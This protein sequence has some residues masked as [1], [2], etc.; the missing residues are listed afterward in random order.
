MLLAL[1]FLANNLLPPLHLFQ[2]TF[3]I[4]KHGTHGPQIL[5]QLSC[6]PHSHSTLLQ[7]TSLGTVA[8]YLWFLCLKL[9]EDTH[10]PSLLLKSLS[11]LRCS[12]NDTS[13]MNFTPTLPV[14]IN[15]SRLCAII[16]ICITPL[17][18][19][20]SSLALTLLPQ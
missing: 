16:A 8:F 15:L 19:L 10:C 12:S 11:S 18:W 13:S 1:H 17:F 6:Q 5:S 20:L 4:S 7:T 2:N 9:G 14:R 3:W